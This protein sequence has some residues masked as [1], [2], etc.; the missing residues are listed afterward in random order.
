MNIDDIFQ[1]GLW[2]QR[3]RDSYKN[4]RALPMVNGEGQLLDGCE[5]AQIILNTYGIGKRCKRD[6]SEWKTK[7]EAKYKDLERLDRE[8]AQKLVLD[9][10]GWKEEIHADFENACGRNCRKW[11]ELR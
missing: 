6:I 11:V 4:T 10:A 1:L 7:L 5:T 8:N 3:F 9:S 2:V